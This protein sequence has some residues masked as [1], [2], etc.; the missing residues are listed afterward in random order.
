[1][2]RKKNQRM[3]NKFKEFAEL[4]GKETDIY[5]EKEEGTWAYNIGAWFLDGNGK[6]HYRISEIISEKGAAKTV[7]GKRY[8]KIDAVWKDINFFLS[9]MKRIQEKNL[10]VSFLS[11]REMSQSSFS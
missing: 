2:R 11:K 8:K 3:E 7:F 1:M 9:A 10:D 6:G 5:I 4:F